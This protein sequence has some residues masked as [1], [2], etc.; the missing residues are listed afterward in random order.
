MAGGTGAGE[1]VKVTGI[2][3]ELAPDALT[4]TVAE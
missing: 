1:T 2:E 3:T 4:V